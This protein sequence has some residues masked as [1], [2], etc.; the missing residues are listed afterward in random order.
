MILK[1][2]SAQSLKRLP[3]PAAEMTVYPELPVRRS[4]TTASNFCTLVGLPLGHCYRAFQVT[5]RR[6][7]DGDMSFGDY[8]HVSLFKV[9]KTYA[10]QS[11]SVFP[12]STIIQWQE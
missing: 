1:K 11:H 3:N 6:Q 8:L 12:V 5:D 2:K 7:S 9:R 4:T 10:H